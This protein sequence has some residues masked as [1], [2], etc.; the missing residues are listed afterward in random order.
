[1]QLT[2]EAGNS[3]ATWLRGCERLRKWW[4][5]DRDDEKR[6]REESYTCRVGAERER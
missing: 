1:V 5:V 2:R 3:T 4:F 6:E